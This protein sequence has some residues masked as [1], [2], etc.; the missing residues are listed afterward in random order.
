[1]GPIIGHLIS[2][3]ESNN[4]NKNPLESSHS[5]FSHVP[6]NAKD[7]YAGLEDSPHLVHG[8]AVRP[9]PSFRDREELAQTDY[10]KGDLHGLAAVVDPGP[11]H[12]NGILRSLQMRCHENF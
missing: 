3:F 1:M 12:E 4:E 6:T 5:R 9:G 7:L 11:D 8:A 2:L 10:L